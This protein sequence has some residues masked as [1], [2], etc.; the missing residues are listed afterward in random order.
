MVKNYLKEIEKLNNENIE[1][2]LSLKKSL[3]KE[4]F[5]GKLKYDLYNNYKNNQILK[6]SPYNL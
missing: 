2:L 1:N 5:S 4:A 3:L 6:N